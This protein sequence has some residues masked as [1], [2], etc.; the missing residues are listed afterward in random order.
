[1]VDM[2]SFLN[3]ALRRGENY[4]ILYAVETFPVYREK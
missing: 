1:M 4:A 2:N 3:F